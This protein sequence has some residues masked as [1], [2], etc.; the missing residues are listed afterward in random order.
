MAIAV[1]T[2]FCYLRAII[3]LFYDDLDTIFIKGGVYLVNTNRQ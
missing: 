1:E 3:S 2:F